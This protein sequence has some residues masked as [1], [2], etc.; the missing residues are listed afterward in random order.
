MTADGAGRADDREQLRA[1]FLAASGLALATRTVLTRDA[2]TR[3]Y[4]RVRATSGRTLLLMDQPRDSG[5][6]PCDPAWSPAQRERKGWASVARLSAGRLE[7]FAAV[8]AH[9]RSIGLR[10]PAIEDLD[11]SNGLALVE[12]FGDE[13]FA[14]SLRVAAD[15][16]T[17]YLQ[18]VKALA[19]LHDAP[20]PAVLSGA[21]GN[22]PLLTLDGTALQAAA[23][24]YL[25]WMPVAEHSPA[26]GPIARAEWR[27]AWAPVVAAEAAAAESVIHR[28]FHAENLIRLPG[29]GVNAV[30][31]ID[32]QDAILANPGVDLHSLLQDARRDVH[33]AV[34]KRALDHY[35]ACRPA[36]DR[37]SFTDRYH[38]SAALNQVRILGILARL[39]TRD[40]K[41]RYRALMPRVRRSLRANLARGRLVPVQDW[42]RC[43]EPE[44]GW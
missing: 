40:A 13:S 36:V 31:V 10:A 38:G 19:V 21:G 35:L 7:A 16:M 24:L 11:V 5:G 23:D 18:A 33:P 1:E 44:C 34:E 30:G 27:Q 6:P 8:A 14:R 2:S 17:L 32:F 29:H 42:F 26:P 39:V 28:D 12:D 20:S 43:H 15:E 9:L 25:D 37:E 22:W 41:P 4:E 3:R